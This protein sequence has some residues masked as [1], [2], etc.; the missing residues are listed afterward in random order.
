MEPYVLLKKAQEKGLLQKE[1]VA[2]TKQEALNLI[3]LPGFSTKEKV[4]EFSGR[5]VGMDVVNSLV[6]SLGG[7]VTIESAAGEGTVITMRMP[8]S[9]TTV[10]SMGLTVGESRYFLPLWVISKVYDQQQV[11]ALLCL[12]QQAMF[13]HYE[14]Q[15]VPVLDLRTVFGLPSGTP[16]AYVVVQSLHKCFCLVVDCVDGQQL[17]AEKPLP[18]GLSKDYQQRSGISG[19]VI[20]ENGRIGYMLSVERLYALSRKGRA[21]DAN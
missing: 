10:E 7:T 18:W 15:L 9:V 19:C 6:S 16:G 5:G 17:T 12:Q 13:L 8:V 11:Q 1:L 21:A 2:Y 14:E 20:L 4:T 3:M